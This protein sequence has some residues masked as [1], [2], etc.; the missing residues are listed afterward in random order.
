M[1]QV[2]VNHGTTIGQHREAILGSALEA[3]R[4]GYPERLSLTRLTVLRASRVL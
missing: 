2:P 1:N 4:S 3:R